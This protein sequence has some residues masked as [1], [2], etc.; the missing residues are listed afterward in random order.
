MNADELE[1]QR[2]GPLLFGLDLC[3]TQID[4]LCSVSSQDEEQDS[5]GCH[6]N[7]A[8]SNHHHLIWIAR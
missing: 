8:D 7:R 1:A 5:C 2:S 3:L 6:Q 4:S